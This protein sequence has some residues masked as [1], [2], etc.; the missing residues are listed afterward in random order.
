MMVSTRGGQSEVTE[1]YF[2]KRMLDAS[3]L[4]RAPLEVGNGTNVVPT[5]RQQGCRE[6]E[7]ELTSSKLGEREELALEATRIMMALVTPPRS[8]ELEPCWLQANRREAA[9]YNA[10]SCMKERKRWYLLDRYL[11]VIRGIDKST[12]EE[13]L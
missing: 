13:Y 1:V 11:R 5:T 2:I 10:G 6:L 9:G 7:M 4:S 8:L 12:D 3:R